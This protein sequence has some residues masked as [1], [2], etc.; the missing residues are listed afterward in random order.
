M[1]IVLADT[2]V[3]WP[4]A[5]QCLMI[6]DEF[7]FHHRVRRLRIAPHLVVDA[8]GCRESLAPPPRLI[9]HVDVNGGPT[10]RSELCRRLRFDFPQRFYRP[11]G[12]PNP[13][14][15]RSAK[16]SSSRSV[17]AKPN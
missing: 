14:A 3:H 15:N 8:Y 5:K 17:A 6:P 16:D 1:S 2:R 4:R 10:P 9:H 13:A 12:F 11:T 7:E